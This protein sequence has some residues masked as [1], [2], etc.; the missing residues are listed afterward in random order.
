MFSVKLIPVRD[1][2]VLITLNCSSFGCV[3]VILT[4]RII[5]MCTSISMLGHQEDVEVL[6]SIVSC[7]LFLLL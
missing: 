4:F 6:K 2:L 1:D 3:I 7:I 5:V